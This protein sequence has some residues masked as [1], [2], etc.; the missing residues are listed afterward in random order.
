M[1]KPYKD[2]DGNV[3]YQNRLVA[4]QDLIFS[5]EDHCH[6][7]PEAFNLRKLKELPYQ[8]AMAENLEILKKECLCNYEFLLTQLRA[9]GLSEVLDNF[10]LALSVWPSDEDLMTIYETMKLST[11]ALMLWPGQLASQLLSR[12]PRD[13]ILKSEYLKLLEKQ[14]RSPSLP[15]VIPSSVSELY[16]NYPKM[17][18]H[19]LAVDS[20]KFHIKE[21]NVRRVCHS[22][23]K[24]LETSISVLV[25]FISN[26]IWLRNFCSF[27]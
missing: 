24:T 2:K 13:T 22:S 8:L 6:K 15:A 4:S 23:Q 10:E 7:G 26:L 16:Q 19:C 18:F 12:I 11:N 14:A 21:F 20:S 3:Q 17:W 1:E 27:E 25:K 5:P 9:C